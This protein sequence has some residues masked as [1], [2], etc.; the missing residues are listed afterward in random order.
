MERGTTGSLLSFYHFVDGSI[1]VLILI[2]P[3]MNTSLEMGQ[4]WPILKSLVLLFAI[5]ILLQMI[6]WIPHQ[7][8]LKFATTSFKDPPSNENQVYMVLFIRI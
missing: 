2:N 4:K 7:T 8:Y 1:L 3:F 5:I 6:I